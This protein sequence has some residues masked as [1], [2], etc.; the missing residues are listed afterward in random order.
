MKIKS[1][2]EFWTDLNIAETESKG[3]PGILSVTCADQK[4]HEKVNEAFFRVFVLC[5]VIA[6]GFFAVISS[7]IS[8]K[9]F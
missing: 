5:I 1:E 8:L 7:L 3:T 6:G 2:G 4:L 9:V